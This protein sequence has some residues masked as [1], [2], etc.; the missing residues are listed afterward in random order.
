[1]NPLIKS[2]E[3]NQFLKKDLKKLDL[4]FNKIGEQAINKLTSYINSGECNLEEL[5]LEGNS[6]GDEN[7]NKLC[8]AINNSLSHKLTSLNVSRNLI[9]DESCFNIANL[10]QHCTQLKIL[11]ISW[12]HI[13][14]LGA[15]L[16]MNKLKK[17]F[18]MKVFD[19]SWNS[20]GTNLNNEPQIE[21]VLPKGVPPKS[22]FFNFEINE[23]RNT[24]MINFRKELIPPKD[25]G[26]KE[27]PGK[28]KADANNKSAAI[29]L[30]IPSVVSH[31]AITPFAKELGEYFKEINTELV[32]LD[33]SH[34]NINYE[35]AEYLAKECRF[36]HK[37][38]GIHLDG[39]EITIDELGF[40]HPM[41]KIGKVPNYY[42][43]SQ[44]YYN[45][46]HDQNRVKTN[47]DKIRKI[48]S[49][50]NCW[51]CQ[52]WREIT[53]TI[54]ADPKIKEP[55]KQ[56]V[57]I[58]LSFE[59]WKAYDTMFYDGSYC[60]VRMCPPGDVLYFFTVNKKPVEDYGAK[61]YQVRD[62]IVYAFEDEFLKEFNE[63]EIKNNYYKQTNEVVKDNNNNNINNNDPNNEG[64]KREKNKENEDIEDNMNN[65]FNSNI[66]QV[67]G[68]DL[69]E[70]S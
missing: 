38:L 52:G 18:E 48:R 39:N 4:S 20:I 13:K 10:L 54:K 23:F 2:I 65:S 68:D 51:I 41:K 27:Q 70:V 63:N 46:N 32:H 62:P 19:I 28:G 44:I 47:N 45:I 16:I 9:T 11:M 64:N 17:N 35:D 55:E 43:N 5:N 49:K 6:L 66:T 36:N 7:I 34:N 3:K 31:R 25:T 14:N 57:K 24:N 61:N 50:N 1:M 30:Q 60:V 53:F 67:M 26:K 12:N 33:I 15:S 21:D 56:F 22:D 29:P 8:E 40:L 37:I 42:A 69:I 58:H 59:N